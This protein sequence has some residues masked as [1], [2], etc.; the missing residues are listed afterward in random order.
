MDGVLGLYDIFSDGFPLFADGEDA[1]FPVKVVGGARS[2]IEVGG[3][4]D[5]T[6]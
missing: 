2:E 4:H 5:E 1:R 6:W 3:C